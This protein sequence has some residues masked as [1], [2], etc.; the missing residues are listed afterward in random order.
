[1]AGTQTR[2]AT[3]LELGCSY[4]ASI[5][6]EAGILTTPPSTEHAA[7]LGCSFKRGYEVASHQQHEQAREKHTI[8]SGSKE[9]VDLK[10]KRHPDGEKT[11]D[12]EINDGS[13]LYNIPLRKQLK[14]RKDP[15]TVEAHVPQFH[16][17][18]EKGRTKHR[19]ASVR[20]YL[21]RKKGG[22][23]NEKKKVQPGN[24][25]EVAQKPATPAWCGV[26]ND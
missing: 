11:P 6:G 7:R 17:N 3:S 26:S 14:S 9:N 5:D 4:K 10:M 18:G 16:Q 2:L 22:K 21:E 12:A 1:V 24:C 15:A 20:D 23:G 19:A 25:C 8:T 13:N